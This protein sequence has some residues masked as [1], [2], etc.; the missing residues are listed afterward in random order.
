MSKAADEA[1]Q[2]WQAMHERLGYYPTQY[3]AAEQAWR[4]A[5]EWQREADLQALAAV[6]Q[7]SNQGEYQRGFLKACE[8]LG[9]KIKEG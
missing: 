1:F 4:A 7:H 8:L 9:R 3:D 2:K 5:C 6:L